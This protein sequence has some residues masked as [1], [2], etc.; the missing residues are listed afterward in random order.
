MQVVDLLNDLYS[1]FDAIIDIHDVYKV[2]TIGNI[3]ASL[4]YKN[5]F[6]SV[7]LSI[8]APLRSGA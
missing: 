4:P 3:F 1:C 7:C 6:L 5:S 2:E 8:I